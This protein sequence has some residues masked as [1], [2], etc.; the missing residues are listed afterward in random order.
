MCRPGMEQTPVSRKAHVAATVITTYPIKQRKQDNRANW[1]VTRR[2][3]SNNY[4]EHKVV[5]TAT[6][7][8]MWAYVYMAPQTILIRWRMEW[9]IVSLTYWPRAYVTL[10]SFISVFNG[11]GLLGQLR[12]PERVGPVLRPCFSEYTYIPKA[13]FYSILYTS[14]ILIYI[15]CRYKFVVKLITLTS[16][17]RVLLEKLIDTQLVKK[18]PFYGTWIFINRVHSWSLSWVKWN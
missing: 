2:L 15:C 13:F 3:R 5:R 1:F 6:S 7:W 9:Q 18:F 4:N 12:E 8:S 10:Q 14:F 11:N 17:S 16:L